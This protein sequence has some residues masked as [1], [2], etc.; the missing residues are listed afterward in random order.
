MPPVRTTRDLTVLLLFILLVAPAPLA[1]A[2]GPAGKPSE[3]GP[4]LSVAEQKLRGELESAYSELVTR[5]Q[6]LARKKDLSKKD[7]LDGF[8]AAGARVPADLSPEDF[9]RAK[10]TLPVLVEMFEPLGALRLIKLVRRGDRAGYFFRSRREERGEITVGLIKFAQQPGTQR[11]RVVKSY[12]T[13]FEPKKGVSAE[14][15]IARTLAADEAF[16]S[17]YDEIELGPFEDRVE[18]PWARYQARFG[19]RALRVFVNGVELRLPAS[20]SGTGQLLAAQARGETPLAADPIFRGVFSLRWGKNELKL[21]YGAGSRT[22]HLEVTLLPR[23]YPL[24]A[25]LAA[26]RTEEAGE[27]TRTFTLERTPPKPFFPEVVSS[28]PEKTYGVVLVESR[29][30]QVH[31]R[32]NG[33]ASGM[34]FVGADGVSFLEGLKPGKNTVEV[35]YRLVD[36]IPPFLARE[37]RTLRLTLV[38]PG[39]REAL[40]LPL[41]GQEAKRTMVVVVK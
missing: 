13:S 31:F 17:L 32:V 34:S 36:R 19:S 3:G 26:V 6:A 5:L 7:L 40:N 25:I 38:F 2:E 28:L 8:R 12:S 21:K 22:D 39:S 20:G 9:A 37:P 16:A 11:F 10:Q 33:S 1:R 35:L 24:P 18:L 30:A 23:G 14:Q 4:R 41:R 29:L 27:L 15:Q